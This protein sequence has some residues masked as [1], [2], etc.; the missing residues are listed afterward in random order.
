MLHTLH[1]STSAS[2]CPVELWCT[3]TKHTNAESYAREF[4]VTIRQQ[5]GENLGQR[6]QHAFAST[7]TESSYA[8]LIGCDCPALTPAHLNRSLQI[9][10]ARQAP[11]V[12]APA[13]DGG[14]VL[15]GLD[16]E[17]PVLFEDI[18]W[19]SDQVLGQTRDRVQQL[20]LSHLELETLWD[21]DR[22]QDLQRLSTLPDKQQWQ[23][24]A[25]F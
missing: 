20:Q 17:Q 4:N 24:F 15:I 7:L 16:S 1:T 18:A 8:L 14:Y 23:K 10:E 11:I 2:L 25:G 12:L 22:P 19:G 6:M 9:L 13:E 5:K 21:L 3:N